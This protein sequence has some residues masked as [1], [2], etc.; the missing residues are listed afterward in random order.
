MS[1][2]I[3]LFGMMGVGKSTVG[4]FLAT[5]LGRGFADTDA[6]IERWRGLPIPDIF[7]LEGEAVFRG[8]EA[9]V[10]RDLSTYHDLV[11]ALGGGAVL[12]D[13]N[14]AD[15]SLTSVLIELR[16]PTEVLVARLSAAAAGRPLLDGDLEERVAAVRAERADRYAAVADHVVDATPPADVVVE[17]ILDWL[18]ENRDLLTP[19]EFEAVMT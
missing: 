9:Q 5:R 11:L 8:Y 2:N 7:R 18:R 12:S 13:D 16:A 17:S 14:V 4:R 1:S 3:A 15:L 6:E 10:V 19:S